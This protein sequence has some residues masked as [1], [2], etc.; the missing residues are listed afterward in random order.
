VAHTLYALLVGINA[1]A[2]E[3]GPLEGCLNDVDHFHSYLTGTF[4]KSALAIEVLKDGDA[5]RGNIIQQFRDHLG[6]ATDGDVALFHYCGHG[7]RWAS[8]TAFREFYPEGKDEGLVCIDSRRPGGFDLADKELAVLI[9]EVARNHP[10]LA[11]ILD[12]CHSG[13]GTRSADAFRGLRPRLTHEVTTERPLDAYLDGYFARLQQKNEPLSIPTSRHILLA[14]CERTQLAQETD[15]A[16]GVFTSTLIEVLGKSGGDLTYADLFVRCRAAVRSRADNQD[17]QFEAYNNFDS[18]SGFLGRNASFTSPRY[19]V[20][21]DHGRWHVDCGAIH[22]VP[23]AP[24]QSVALALYPED[25]QG[26]LAG[27]A[28]TVQVGP[29]K[30]E[31]TLG[32]AGNE[33]V[34]YRAEITSLPVAPLLV[35]CKGDADHLGAL[36]HALDRNDQHEDAPIGVTLT[37]IEPGTRYALSLEGSKL[38]LTQRETGLLIQGA[39][40]MDGTLDTAAKWLRPALRQV[41]RWER[42]LALQNPGT[43]IDASLFD[44]VFARQLDDGQEHVFPVGEIVLDFTG[45]QVR[46]KFKARNRTSQAL[47]LVLEYFTTPSATGTAQTGYGIHILKN[48]PID[49]GDAWVTLWGDGPDDY[50]YLEDGVNESIEPFKL[51]VSTEKVDDFLLSEEDLAIGTMATGTR[52]VGSVTPMNKLVHRNEWF[53]RNISVR[54]VRR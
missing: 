26:H 40:A 15:D 3:V 50:F 51:F 44:V 33:S 16:S 36:Q 34:R 7:A 4:D 2:P 9:S 42:S 14:A 20:Y 24:E 1:Y 37:D 43:Q 25:D 54:V 28:T 47:H 12:C 13:S 10:H 11:V 41:A 46:G 49:P 52:S 19:S 17:P 8:A 32:F 48:D 29:Q 22:G 35:Y 6:R 21:F 5:T 30:S 18:R 31:V 39:E 53:T 23:T 27:T 38:R 45:D